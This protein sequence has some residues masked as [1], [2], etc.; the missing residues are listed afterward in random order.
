MPSFRYVVAFKDQLK[1]EKALGLLFGSADENMRQRTAL[2]LKELI[3]SSQGA[4]WD[5]PLST[6]QHEHISDVLEGNKGKPERYKDH[7]K[8]FWESTSGSGCALPEL[9]HLMEAIADAKLGQQVAGAARV[10]LN[11][12]A[13]LIEEDS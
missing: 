12:A 8:I 2:F 9:F 10:W 3:F 1:G 13:K 11:L 4:T 6:L 5:F 7:I